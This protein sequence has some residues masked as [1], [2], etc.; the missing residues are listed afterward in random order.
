M[1]SLLVPIALDVLMVRPGAAAEPHADIAMR[2]VQARSGQRVRSKLDTEPFALTAA[3]R[4]PGAYLHWALPDAMTRGDSTP[5]SITLPI[6]PDRWLVLRLVTP[7]DGS[8]RQL[9]GWLIP[10]AGAAQPIIHS[11]VLSGSSAAPTLP[12]SQN[13]MTVLGPGSFSWAAC[14]D[15]IEGR[16]G[17]HDDLAGVTGAVSYLVCG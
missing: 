11:D 1:G 14:Y 2:E 3:P 7:A 16:F 6:I 5:D 9:T 12:A 4:A 17:L 15:N 13:T 10:D 8:A